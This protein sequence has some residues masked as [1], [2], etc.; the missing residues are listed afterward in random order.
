MGS[1]GQKNQAGDEGFRNVKT[2]NPNQLWRPHAVF[3]KILTEVQRVS[4]L[5][6]T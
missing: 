2:L 4:G 5:L 1:G 3:M 6:N